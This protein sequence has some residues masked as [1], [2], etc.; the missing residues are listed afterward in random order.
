MR[1]SM[2]K[3]RNTKIGRMKNGEKTSSWQKRNKDKVN[4]K[5]R[6]WYR[7]HKDELFGRILD[8]YGHKCN[9]CG[10]PNIKFLTVDH[11][12]NNGHEHR[13]KKGQ[14]TL[15]VYRDVIKQGFPPDYQ[16]LCWNCNI[17]RNLCKICPHKS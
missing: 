16:I 11:V 3:Y 5:Q 1:L 14:I 7:K 17:C 8:Y 2:K 13:K 10:E 15:G 4:L 9:C 12:N 6:R